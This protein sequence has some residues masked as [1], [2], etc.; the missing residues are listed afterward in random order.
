[1]AAA[2]E[3]AMLDA[4]NELGRRVN[5]CLDRLEARVLAAETNAVARLVNSRGLWEHEAIQPLVGVATN[6]AIADFPRTVRELRA[7]SADR[8]AELLRLLDQPV[9]GTPGDRLERLTRACGIRVR[10]F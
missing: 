6:E 5:E 9:D 3:N 10:T 7:I 8:V 4:I 2:P 1:M